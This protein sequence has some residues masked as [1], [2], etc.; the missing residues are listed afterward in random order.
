MFMQDSAR[1]SKRI[2]A[3]SLTLFVRML[4][5]MAINLYAVRV[6]LKGL[7]TADYGIFNAVAGVVLT[8]TFLNTT[9][10]VSIQRFY[11]YSIGKDDQERLQKIFSTSLN[12]VILLSVVIFLIFETVGLW[13]LEAK[14]IE[15]E[16]KIPIERLQA[17][18]WIFQFALF[19][20]IL[21]LLQL[22]Y[23]AAI[24]AHED[25]GIYA[26]ISFLE[27]LARLIVAYFIGKTFFDGLIFY[28]AGLLFV[29]VIVFITYALIGRRQYAE[30]HFQ[31][32]TEK[33]L[34]IEL[35]SFS[36][37]AMYGAV[38]GVGIVQG[39][40]ILLTIFFGPVTV[41][42]Y[43][44]ANQIYN[45][46]NSLCNSIVLAFRP[47]MV[48][49]YAE[50]NHTFLIRLFN[51]SN[52]LI[53]YLL[54][55]VILP[56]IAEMRTILGWWLD[57]ASED[58]VTFSRLMLIMMVVLA[59]HNPITTIIQ[60]TGRI[61]KYYLTVDTMTLCSLLITWGLFNYGFPS[62]AAFFSMIGVC[63]TAHIIRLFCLKKVYPLF[64]YNNYVKTLVLPSFIIVI[65]SSVFTIGLHYN[66][67][68]SSLRFFIVAL[69]SPMMTFLLVY[70]FGITRQEKEQLYAFLKT[71]NKF[72]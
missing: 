40:N 69:A 25:M 63:F 62:K 53:V 51:S 45:A 44:I 26:I 66:I 43:A 13:F 21:S 1:K 67:Q 11:S 20:F 6:V 15:P 23:T 17:T 2:A 61:K 59:L 14:M 41:A 37:W 24:F 72:R 33:A 16:G 31:K 68:S 47:A 56:L 65:L 27:C 71:F 38:A 12:I 3:N 57:E 5:I 7:G 70:L 49:S 32:V 50:N 48:K 42:C 10:A 28:G 55:A 36:G 4:A 9:L 22:P 46:T 8:S 39:T 35:L 19:S 58:M 30:C 54:L 18:I 60:S 52:K 29:A 64:S 34:Y